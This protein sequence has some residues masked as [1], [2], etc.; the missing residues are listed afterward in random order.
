MKTVKYEI[1]YVDDVNKLLKEVYCADFYVVQCNDVYALYRRNCTSCGHMGRK[2][3]KLI[4]LSKSMTSIMSQIKERIELDG[5]KYVDDN[6]EEYKYEFEVCPDMN[7]EI[8]SHTGICY[9]Y[10]VSTFREWLD[11]LGIGESVDVGMDLIWVSLS[12]DNR[13][14]ILFDGE[15]YCVSDEMVEKAEVFVMADLYDLKDYGNALRHVLCK[16]S[17]LLETPSFFDTNSWMRVKCL[18]D[19]LV[20][21]K[22]KVT[23]KNEEIKQL[24]N[25]IR[26]QKQE[27]KR[28][29]KRVDTLRKYINKI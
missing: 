3:H 5:I 7:G 10:D 9:V 8:N 2:I 14:H 28:V 15:I 27:L 18:L 11:A 16:C 23:A 20:M 21:E 1:N 25:E 22:D 6:F 19:S 4:A 17:P 26:Q 24:K 12:I 13:R 29:Y